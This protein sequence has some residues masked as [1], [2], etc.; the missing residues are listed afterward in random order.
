[1][2]DIK[3]VVNLYTECFPEDSKEMIELFFRERLGIKNCHYIKIDNKLA[4]QLF[5]VDK[6][7]VYEK[8]NIYLPF[9]VGLGTAKEHRYKGLA[10]TLLID[11][12][13]K[14]DGVPFISLYPFSHEFYEK[15][16]F[17]TVSYDYNAEKT[18]TVISAEKAY[19]IYKA[20]TKNLD[21]YIERTQKDFDLLDEITKLDGTY[22]CLISEGGYTNGE[23]T[24]LLGSKGAAKGTMTRIV[25]LF[26]AIKLSK[27]SFPA[28][29]ITD[30]LIKRNNVIISSDNGNVTFCENYEKEIDISVLTA[31]MFG[32]NF[33]YPYQIKNLNGHLL[34]RY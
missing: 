29:K 16:S 22:F 27:L 5:L 26:A 21:F 9:I 24:V 12:L 33:F 20:Y 10:K 15:M 6:T 3:E 28:I 34:D 18:D 32:L 30:C 13:E 4:C 23:E 25:D 11:V 14:L 7:L 1:M 2:I 8:N 17:A 31:A 19:S